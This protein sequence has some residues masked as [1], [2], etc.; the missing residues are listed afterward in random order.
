VSGWPGAAAG[1]A[2]ALAGGSWPALGPVPPGARAAG[3][4][5]PWPHPAS[6]ISTPLRSTAGHRRIARLLVVY[7]AQATYE[8][9]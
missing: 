6:P 9:M 4:E 2:G 1:A 7:L 8:P 5:A 3:G